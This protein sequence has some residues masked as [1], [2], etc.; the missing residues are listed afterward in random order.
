MR[1]EALRWGMTASSPHLERTLQVID[2]PQHPVCAVRSQR[3]STQISRRRCSIGVL[4]S[5]V[6]I[7]TAAG[8]SLWSSAPA[9]SPCWRGCRF[10]PGLNDADV[11]TPPAWQ[12]CAPP[13][14]SGRTQCF[15]KHWPVRK[16]TNKKNQ[17][18]L[19]PRLK[20]RHSSSKLSL[21]YVSLTFF[22]KSTECT[23]AAAPAP[24]LTPSSGALYRPRPESSC[25]SLE[26]EASACV[27]DIDSTMFRSRRR[28]SMVL[29]CSWSLSFPFSIWE[30]IQI[31]MLGWTYKKTL[32]QCSIVMQ[33]AWLCFPNKPIASL[34]C[35]E[36]FLVLRNVKDFW[37]K[38]QNGNQVR[39]RYSPQTCIPLRWM[40]RHS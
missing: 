17:I 32:K 6:R 20:L 12:S 30:T 28:C 37:F 10:F 15:L 13:L 27:R 33:L 19:D 35:L 8:L 25:H 40:G 29:P 1:H 31:I 7:Q 23:E 3:F 34:T 5:S 18:C 14:G 36:S 21:I 39:L 9:D 24:I 26:L 11:R 16:K 38:Y 4:A 2:P 22:S